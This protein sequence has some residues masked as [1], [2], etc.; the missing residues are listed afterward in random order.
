MYV[1]INNT[2]GQG[3]KHIVCTD[4]STAQTI[5]KVVSPML[6]DDIDLVELD[7]SP[8]PEARRSKVS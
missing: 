4:P 8:W 5:T 6:G 3:L 7:F 2:L 1:L